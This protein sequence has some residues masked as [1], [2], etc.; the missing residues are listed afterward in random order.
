[1]DAQ[2]LGGF[3]AQIRKEQ[4]MTQLDLA[5]KLKVTDKAVSRWER[6]LG[7]PD[8]NTI[9]PLAEALGVTVLEVMRAERIPD[10][11]VSQDNAAEAV[12]ETI[13]LVKHQ[14]RQERRQLLQITLGVLAAVGIY[15]LVE[16]YDLDGV[17]MWLLPLACIPL[18]I[19]LGI[20]GI[21]QAVRRQPCLRTFLWAGIC[22]LVAVSPLLIMVGCLVL[23]RIGELMK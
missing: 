11:H 3:I 1:M 21:I 13:D 7:L 15:F 9:E 5:R 18:T 22:G 19:T 4:H 12:T 10:E 16:A 6:G 23:L 14:R 8:I 20:Y 2:K 17:L